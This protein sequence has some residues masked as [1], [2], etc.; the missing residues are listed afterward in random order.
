MCSVYTNREQTLTFNL[1]STQ[2]PR[3]ECKHLGNDG[4]RRRLGILNGDYKRDACMHARWHK[5]MQIEN[6]P[7]RFRR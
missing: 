1:S 3:L 5:A 6:I 4:G 7:E 2:W